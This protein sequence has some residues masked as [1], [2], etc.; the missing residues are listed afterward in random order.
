[1]WP[2]HVPAGVEVLPVQLAGRGWRLREAPSTDLGRIA[3]D[4]AVA[5]ARLGD[6][7][8]A[9]F[10]HS[11]GSWLGL[12]VVRRL[13][14]LGRAPV[15]LIASGRQT[16]LVGNTQPPMSHLDDVMFVE[17]VQR[18]YGGIPQE[19]LREREMLA[20]LL[21][22]LRADIAALEKYERVE[23]PIETPIHAVV[24]AVDPVVS[25]D[26]IAGWAAETRGAFSMRTFGGG[27]FFFQPDPRPLIDWLCGVLERGL[28]GSLQGNGVP[29][30]AMATR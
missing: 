8:V 20:L 6:E 17:E 18:R 30:M 11:M 26:E 21:P 14:A 27:H 29:A 2:D 3:S 10:G 5:I 19:L 24:G 13:E 7:P 28:G 25:A 15:C 16:P 9:V 23:A 22:A 4:L 12:E 1:M